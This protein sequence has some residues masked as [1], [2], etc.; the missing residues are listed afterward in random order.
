MTICVIFDQKAD[1]VLEIWVKE[2]FRLLRILGPSAFDPLADSDLWRSH[3]A[4]VATASA[5]LTERRM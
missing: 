5:E 3:G 4:A 1:K 2:E